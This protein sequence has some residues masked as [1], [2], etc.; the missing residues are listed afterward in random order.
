[1]SRLWKKKI[2]LWGEWSDFIFI[3]CRVG[4]FW[5]FY[6]CSS[7][8]KAEHKETDKIR[9]F[10]HTDLSLR[11]RN[12]IIFKVVS[13]IFVMPHLRGCCNWKRIMHFEVHFLTSFHFLI[14]REQ[15]KVYNTFWDNQI[16]KYHQLEFVNHT[17]FILWYVKC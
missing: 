7:D 12:Q 2:H 6:I 3:L 14:Y 8:N 5:L 4:L 17:W 16:Q 13:Y 15:W 1:M 9:A 11:L 10:P